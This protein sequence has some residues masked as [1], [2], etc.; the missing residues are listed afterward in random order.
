[1][2]AVGVDNSTVVIAANKDILQFY[3]VNTEKYM[4]WNFSEHL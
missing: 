1:M 4:V 3:M 2:S